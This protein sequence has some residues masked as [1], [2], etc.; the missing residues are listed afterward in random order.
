[1]FME[2]TIKRLKNP[3]AVTRLPGWYF[4]S[5]CMHCA[6]LDD[7]KEHYG[8]RCYDKLHLI[9]EKLKAGGTDM[10][11]H[12]EFRL[13]IKSSPFCKR[14]KRVYPECPIC[15]ALGMPQRRC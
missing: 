1:M 15:K 13:L 2:L 12:M 3:V 14:I 5:F 11:T 7:R 9:A 6:R 10:M 8:K 4:G